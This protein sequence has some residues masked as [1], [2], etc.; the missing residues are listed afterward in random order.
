MDLMARSKPARGEIV[1]LARVEP[2][3]RRDAFRQPMTTPLRP[4]IIDELTAILNSA[5]ARDGAERSGTTLEGLRAIGRDP[6]VV[7]AKPPEDNRGTY[8]MAAGSRGDPPTEFISVQGS[9]AWLAAVGNAAA[10]AAPGAQVQLLGSR[11]ARVHDETHHLVNAEGVQAL[12]S[13]QAPCLFC[14]AYLEHWEYEHEA[15]P[16][17]P[18]WPQDWRHPTL[19]FELERTGEA[20]DGAHEYPAVKITT[21]RWGF[22]YYYVLDRR[23]QPAPSKPPETTR[24]SGS[25][26]KAS[27]P[28]P[29]A[30]SGKGE[31]RERH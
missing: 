24:A 23:P 13:T 3:A 7:R 16:A 12:K 25:K 29:E 9:P 2:Q 27:E 17:K 22:R 31:G 20:L 6:N 5:E 26:R 1:Q 30:P 10:A 8:G 14:Y 15:L 18:N 4:E 19:G 11:E 21:E 28:L